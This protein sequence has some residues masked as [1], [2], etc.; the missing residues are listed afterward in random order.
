MRS[1]I[2]VLL[3]GLCGFMTA[4]SFEPARF[5]SG[6]AF[7]QLSPMTTGGGEVLL[8]LDVS[9]SGEVS[10]VKVLRTTPPLGDLLQK[11]ASGWR[12]TPARDVPEGSDSPVAVETKVLVAGL[13]R[14]PAL[15]DAPV[16][17]EVPADVSPP[18][19]EIPFPTTMI[20]PAYPPTAYLHL[21]QTVAV[22]ISLDA[23]GEV[24]TARVIR[25]VEGL[26]GAALEAARGWRF[27]PARRE[28]E[29]V[30]SFAYVVFGFREPVVSD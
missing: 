28:G 17:G 19:P 4:G 1:I 23:K 3:I 5:E 25:E 16:L 21:S 26:S 6:S 22:E 15:Y 30:P 20:P 12:F 8:E 14:P 13:F 7:I 2:P 11:A 27:R 29:A 18:S 10:A 9:A 24:E